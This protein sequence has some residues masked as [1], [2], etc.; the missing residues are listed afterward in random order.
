MTMTLFLFYPMRCYVWI[1]V[2]SVD[3]KILVK[4]T[5]FFSFC[6]FPLIKGKIV[7]KR[8]GLKKFEL[9]AKKEFSLFDF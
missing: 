9:F 7:T 6:N 4:A 2:E 1:Y 8:L 3:F 5:F